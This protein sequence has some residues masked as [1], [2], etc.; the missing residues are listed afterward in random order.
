MAGSLLLGVDIGTS[1]T[2]GVLCSPDGAILASATIEH[3]TSF[4]R[5]GWAEHDADGLWWAEFVAIARQLTAGPYSGN[6][7]GAVAVSAI[8]PCMVPLDGDGHPLRSAILYGIDTRA[9]AEIDLLNDVLGLDN[10]FSLSGMALTS[11]TV[12]P[13]ILWL[14]RHEPE[15]FA[16]TA[17]IHSSS[18]YVVFKLTGEHVLDRHSASY[19]APLFNI[20]TLEWDTRF[21]SAVIDPDRLPR[22]GDATGIAGGVCGAASAKTGIPIGTP[23]TFGTID[24]AAEA[25]SV[26]VHKPGDTML[27]YG[28][29]MFL[30]GT[31]VAPQ[32]DPR[33]WT[34]AHPLPGR[35]AVTCGM[36][37]SGLLTTWFC[38]V[39]TGRQ[40]AD[41]R[42]STFETL[43]AEA[44]ATPAGADGLICL[45]YFA[46]ER[47]PIQDPEARGMFAGLTLRHSRAHLFRAVVEGIAFGARHNL[48]AMHEMGA[49]PERLIAVG[50]GTMNSLW[51]QVVSDITGV[52]QDIPERTIGACLGDAF[53]A[54]LGSGLVPDVDALDRDWVR[55]VDKIEADPAVASRYDELYEVYLDLYRQTKGSMH[56]LG[57]IAAS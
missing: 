17:M 56:R 29:T 18:D 21:A 31:V 30:L 37:T 44:T 39:T 51:L 4:P 42:D 47:S 11:Q 16:R 40:R 7:I 6:D 43:I 15:L 13:K 41:G 2:K 50:G 8:G 5:T 14:K 32:P 1:S 38:D 26:G 33:M 23:V 35:R 57:K 24:A 20:E 22:L 52:S 48:D 28:S 19:F 10:I 25:V 27:M 9:T 3:E 49:A 36:A 45:P 34:T 12:G 53:M 54:G 46:G 55:I